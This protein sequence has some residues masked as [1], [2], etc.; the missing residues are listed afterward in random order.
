[1]NRA[2]TIVLL[3]AILVLFLGVVFQNRNASVRDALPVVEVSEQEALSF[4]LNCH[5]VDGK[6]II[7]H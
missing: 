1:M 7:I 5:C 4:A 3:A 2:T 6:N